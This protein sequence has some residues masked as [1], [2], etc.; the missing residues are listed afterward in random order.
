MCHQHTVLGCAICCPWLLARIS[1]MYLLNGIRMRSSKHTRNSVVSPALLVESMPHDVCC[2]QCY[3]PQLPPT[4]CTIRSEVLLSQ[5]HLVPETCS[6]CSTVMFLTWSCMQRRAPG[7]LQALST[8]QGRRRCS[9]VQVSAVRLLL[10]RLLPLLLPQLLPWALLLQCRP[11][12][13]NI[14]RRNSSTVQFRLHQPRCTTQSSS[15]QRPS[16]RFRSHLWRWRP[17]HGRRHH[18]CQLHREPPARQQCCSG[19]VPP[20]TSSAHSRWTSWTT[21][22]VPISVQSF[23]VLHHLDVCA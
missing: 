23:D 15:R 14:S 4:R 1:C 12:R 13:P 3:A 17:C 19:R 2:R 10:P 9:A 22:C 16:R 21:R 20:T 18:H 5:S 8:P 11:E 7:R 6:S